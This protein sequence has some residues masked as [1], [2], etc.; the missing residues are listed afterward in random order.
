MEASYQ[1][2]RAA[3]TAGETAELSVGWKAGQLVGRNKVSIHE[4]PPIMSMQNVSG[5]NNMLRK[6]TDVPKGYWDPQ[7]GKQYGGEWKQMM[8]KNDDGTIVMP[9]KTMVVIY[10]KSIRNRILLFCAQN[11]EMFLQK[12]SKFC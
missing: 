10:S 8:I 9:G 1:A 5:A 6:P 4:G 11:H 7:E 12:S 3:K 2:E